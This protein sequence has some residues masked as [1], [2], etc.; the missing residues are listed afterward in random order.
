MLKRTS[1]ISTLISFALTTLFSLLIFVNVHA[2]EFKKTYSTSI[3][4]DECIRQSRST[5]ASL[6]CLE[7]E[8]KSHDK[9]LNNNYTLALNSIEIFRKKDLRNAQRAWMKYRDKKCAFHY[10]KHSGFGGLI[11]SE[12]CLMVETIVRADELANLY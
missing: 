1:F 11:D 7:T 9:R 6:A 3:Q 5:R 10:H 2:E 8:T 12:S 4:Y